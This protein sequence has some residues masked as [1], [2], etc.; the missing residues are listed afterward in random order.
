MV[1]QPNV[2]C[3]NLNFISLA[4]PPQ[5]YLMQGLLVQSIPFLIPVVIKLKCALKSHGWLAL[6]MDL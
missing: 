3:Y 6:L 2:C 4:F 1:D 5:I